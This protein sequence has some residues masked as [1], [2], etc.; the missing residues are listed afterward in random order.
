M[1]KVIHNEKKKFPSVSVVVIGLNG[2]D[3][4]SSCLKSVLA[5]SLPPDEII[6]VDSGSSDKRVEVAQ[7]F[8][9]L[10]IQLNTLRTTPGLCRN[11]GLSRCKSEFVQFVDGDMCLESSWLSAALPVIINNPKIGSKFGRVRELGRS[12]FDRTVSVDWTFRTSGQTSSPG[13]GGL[14]RT[15]ALKE[16]GGYS[17]ILVAGEEPELGY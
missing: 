15:S 9:L 12:V 16:I 14:S 1:K 2:E 13:S 17:P 7:H 4:L 6:Y 10:I 5:L 3:H 11:Q 8:P